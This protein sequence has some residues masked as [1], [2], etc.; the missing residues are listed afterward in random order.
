MEEYFSQAFKDTAGAVCHKGKVFCCKGV[1]WSCLSVI[2]PVFCQSAS[3]EMKP[4]FNHCPWDIQDDPTDVRGFVLLIFLLFSP[5][6]ACCDTSG[7]CRELSHEFG[8][9]VKKKKK[10]WKKNTPKI[11]DFRIMDLM[12]GGVFQEHKLDN[13]PLDSCGKRMKHFILQTDKT[14]WKGLED[15][16]QSLLLPFYPHSG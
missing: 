8:L 15:R 11:W 7:D 5:S 6:F 13:N 9:Q 2:T 3:G 10:I 1:D 12:T 4:Q 14:S 16:S